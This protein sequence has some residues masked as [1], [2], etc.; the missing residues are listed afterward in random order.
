L[1]QPNLNPTLKKGGN[2]SDKPG[3]IYTDSEGWAHSSAKECVEANLQIESV[4]AQ[5]VTGGNCGQD[6]DNVP[7]NSDK[8]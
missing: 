8:E 4:N 5:Y 6:A 2:M 7:D 1:N 3:D